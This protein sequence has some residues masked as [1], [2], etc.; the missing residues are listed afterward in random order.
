MTQEKNFAFPQNMTRSLIYHSQYVELPLYIHLRIEY[1]IFYPF[2]QIKYFK[3]ILIVDVLFIVWFTYTIAQEM[4]QK[5][6]FVLI[7]N[8]LGIKVRIPWIDF[9][10]SVERGLGKTNQQAI[11]PF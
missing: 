8:F 6:L 3:G 9:R 5:L 7:S 10:G 4:E 11:C 2:S 1:N